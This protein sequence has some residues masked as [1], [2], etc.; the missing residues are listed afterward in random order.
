MNTCTPAKTEIKAILFDMDNT[1]FDFAAA[2]IISC[3]KICEFLGK[4]TDWDLMRYFLNS[5]LG[6]ESHANIEKFMKDN[7]IYNEAD[8]ETAVCIYESVKLSSLVLYDNVVPTLEKIRAAGIKTA[9]ITDAESSQTK[10]RLDKTGLSKYFDCA[11]SPDISGARKPEPPTFL[12]ALEK[13]GAEI[14]ETMVVGDSLRREIEPANK[15]GMTSVYAKYGD[16]MKIPAKDVIPDYTIEN[17]GELAG[18]L[19]LE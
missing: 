6:Y 7:G 19:N 15:L 9:I 14:M 16:W 4:G 10:K 18:I 11:V 2:K 17:F 1:L 8:Y 12:C 3:G 5:G 13:L